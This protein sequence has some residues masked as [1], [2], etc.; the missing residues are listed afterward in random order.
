MA[1]REL[2]LVVDDD[3]DIRDAT[4]LLLE[5]EGFEVAT[6]ANGGEARK[7]VRARR[8]AVILLDIMMN[9]DT[10]GFDLAY[11]LK[12]DPDLAGLPI[13]IMTSFLEKVAEEGPDAF[14]HVLGE[15]WPAKWMFE[16]P[17][18]PARL[19]AKI[20]EVLGGS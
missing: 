10:E 17:V 3:R 4:K 11:E 5:A 7:A 1:K 8:P 13:I 6:A 16:K 12:D 18:E 14:Q 9:T 15:K 19:V 20:R 2:I